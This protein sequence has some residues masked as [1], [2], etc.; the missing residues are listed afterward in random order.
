MDRY[1]EPPR[2]Q[3]RLIG[4]TGALASGKTTAAGILRDHGFRVVD[5]DELAKGMLLDPDVRRQIR[6]RL[7]EDTYLADGSPDRKRI[8][9][10]VFADREKR[11]WLNGLIHPLVRRRLHQLAA[12][13]HGPLVY[14]VPL[15]F[16]SGAYR[17]TDL[18][19]MI[20]APLEERFR[21]AR[22]RNGWSREEFLA[23]ESAQMPPERKRDLADC[24]IENDADVTGLRDRL[25]RLIEILRPG[26]QPGQEI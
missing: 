20:D 13:G 6:T 22:E 19:I 21:R 18:N 11:E 3:L 8:A 2:K 23:R 17:E 5:A 9:D 16:E 12:E 1:P 4:L 26:L 15:L 10:L 25:E 7:G 14:D 24:V